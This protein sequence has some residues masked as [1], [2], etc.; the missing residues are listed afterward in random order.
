M[1]RALIFGLALLA[2]T[3]CETTKGAGKDLQ[4]A[5]DAIEDAAKT[6]QKSF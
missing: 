1:T 3:A 2:L 4:K 5:G 6:V